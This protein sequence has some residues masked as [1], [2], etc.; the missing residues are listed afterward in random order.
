ME[1]ISFFLEKFKS[2]GLESVAV[3]RLFIE[4]VE[5]VLHVKLQADDVVVKSDVVYVKAHPTLKSELYLKRTL[6]AEELSKVLGAVK[7]SSIR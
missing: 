3:K 4:Q 2:L 7:I 6:L 1:Q 5:K